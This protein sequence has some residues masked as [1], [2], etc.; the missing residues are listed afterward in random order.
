MASYRQELSSVIPRKEGLVHDVPSLPSGKPSGT[1]SY[2]P[3]GIQGLTG[4]DTFHQAS[5]MLIRVQESE[6]YQDC[7][8]IPVQSAS[9]RVIPHHNTPHVCLYTSP[10]HRSDV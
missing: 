9:Y 7:W 5:D 6:H 4:S 10:A 8:L 1:H 2:R 3:P